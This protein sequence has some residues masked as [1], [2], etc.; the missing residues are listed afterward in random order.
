MVLCWQHCC[1]PSPVVTCRRRVLRTTPSS[2]NILRV[3]RPTP[4]LPLATLRPARTTPMVMSIQATL[5]RAARPACTSTAPSSRSSS[6]VAAGATG[7]RITLGI[8]R[9]T[10]CRAVS[11]SAER[12]AASTRVAAALPRR[13]RRAVR[14]RASIRAVDLPG[15]NRSATHR[16]QDSIPPP[17]G[18]DSMGRRVSHR[19]GSIPADAALP[20]RARR[21][22]RRRARNNSMASQASIRPRGRAPARTPLPRRGR[23]LR[24]N[25]TQGLRLRHIRNT[26][27]AG[28]AADPANTADP[29]PW[30]CQPPRPSCIGPRRLQISL[31]QGAITDHMTSEP[32][33]IGPYGNGPGADQIPFQAPA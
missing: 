15:H 25:H 10:P 28:R 24:P 29:D 16:R 12:P 33:E 14:R 19:P 21:D 4:L 9:P 17:V 22:A 18:P 11:N 26:A 7:T 2:R 20:R 5:K 1:C 23:D 31:V 8:T 30:S 6:S 27:A 13:G 3:T 32:N